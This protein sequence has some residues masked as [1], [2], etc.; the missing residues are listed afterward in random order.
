MRK[1]KFNRIKQI[2]IVQAIAIMW[3]DGLGR[4]G[5]CYDFVCLKC[6]TIDPVNNGYC[7]KCG[8]KMIRVRPFKICDSCRTEQSTYNEYCER[9]GKE[10]EKINYRT[11]L[12]RNC[13]FETKIEKVAEQEIIEE[14]SEKNEKNNN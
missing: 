11:M 3:T 2:P 4:R 12:K 9:C 14:G 8:F 6:M 1:K 10:L 5:Y 13:Y 7:E